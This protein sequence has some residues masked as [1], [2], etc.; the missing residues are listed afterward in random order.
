MG[1]LSK[2]GTLKPSRNS[3]ARIGYLVKSDSSLYREGCEAGRA[4]FPQSPDHPWRGSQLHPSVQAARR[5]PPSGRNCFNSSH[6][7][8]KFIFANGVNKQALLMRSI[9]HRTRKH[10]DFNVL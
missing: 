4:K 9:A 3:Q 7:V 8:E 5:F 6:A 10:R 2:I 1:A